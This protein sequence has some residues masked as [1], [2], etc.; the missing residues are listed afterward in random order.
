MQSLQ[1]CY[2]EELLV[3]IGFF[4]TFSPFLQVSKRAQDMTWLVFFYKLISWL[5][6]FFFHGIHLISFAKL[7]FLF[8]SYS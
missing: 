5:V 4:L 1:E 8:C 7:C 2:V 6:H 3:Y